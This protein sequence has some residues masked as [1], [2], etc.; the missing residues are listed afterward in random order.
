MTTTEMKLTGLIK[1]CPRCKRLGKVFLD[2][3]A[4]YL[5]EWPIR[6]SQNKHG[7]DGRHR[8]IVLRI[9]DLLDP[10]LGCGYDF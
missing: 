6:G 9:E 7:A 2:P 3:N 8:D 5:I 10:E 1:K 4:S